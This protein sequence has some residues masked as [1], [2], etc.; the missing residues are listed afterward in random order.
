[1]YLFINGL[2]DL[3]WDRGITQ[4][5]RLVEMIGARYAGHYVSFGSSMNDPYNP[6]HERIHAA[7]RRTAPRTLVAQHPGADDTVGQGNIWTAEQYD[8]TPLVDYVMHATGVAGNLGL[9]CHNAIAWSLRLYNH[10]PPKPVVNAETW[11]EGEGG[12]TAEMTAQLGYLSFL[13]GSAGYTY[14]TSLWDAK[15]TDLP[16]WK[17]L[18]GA[19]YM[20]YMYDFFVALDGGRPLRP[21]HELIQNQATHAEERM[22]VGVSTDGLTYAAFLPRGGTISVDLTTLARTIAVTWYD[23]LTGHY[24]DQG[25]TL[26]GAVRSFASPFGTRPSALVLI[27]Q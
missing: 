10:E 3:L 25:T 4:Y 12:G 24:R 23:P 2:V 27:A 5:E 18:R 16:A 11:Y 26:G 9:A 22:V 8:D 7:I 21:R 13:S 14:G 17:A 19:T 6:V 1:M 20:Q 15:D